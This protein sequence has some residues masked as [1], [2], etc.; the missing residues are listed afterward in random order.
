[1]LAGAV[2][3]L[4]PISK[5][6]VCWQLEKIICIISGTVLLPCSAHRNFPFAKSSIVV[7]QLFNALMFQLRRHLRKMRTPC[8]KCLLL[9]SSLAVSSAPTPHLST[10]AA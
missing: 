7:H 2:D 5:S 4:M 8:T 1:M 3:P 6:T 10:S 9:I